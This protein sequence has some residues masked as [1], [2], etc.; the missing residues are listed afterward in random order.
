[1]KIKILKTVITLKNRQT[2]KEKTRMNGSK[3]RDGIL[4]HL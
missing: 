4:E 3:N 1:M 2:T